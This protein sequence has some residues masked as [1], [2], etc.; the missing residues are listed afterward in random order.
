MQIAEQIIANRPYDS[1]NSFYKINSFQGS[2]VTPS[3][4]IQLIKAGCFDCFNTNR[5]AVMK[6]YFVLSNQKPD[7]LTMQ[8]MSSIKSVMKL[9]KE[10][11]GGYNFYKYI[12][13]KQFYFG[14]HPKFKSKKLYWLDN[15]ALRF[16]NKNCTEA[17]NGTDYWEEDDKIV[18][19][20]KSIEKIL[21]PKLDNVKDYINTSKFIDEYY[22][23]SLRAKYNEALPNQDPNHWSM[24][25]VSYY[26]GEHEMHNIDYDRYNLTHFADIPAE[27]EFVE[28]TSRGRT[29]KQFDLYA[30]CGTVVAKNDNNHYFSLL[31]PDNEVVNCKLHRGAYAA[32]K[33]QYSEV[34]DGKKTVLEKPWLSRGTMLIVSGYRRGEE[35]V[36]KKYSNSIYRHQLQKVLSINQNGNTIIQ[37]ERLGGEE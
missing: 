32:Y 5:I 17:I 10:V 22:K 36:C 2:L 12:T 20:D 34:V 18:V 3:K 8:N 11:F 13:Q 19:V 28:R 16:F 29:W 37:S 7:K 23:A 21:K 30:I 25:T 27:P 31:T 35:F 4:F 15:K 24:E 6:R 1:F 33:A 14:P 9:P 26:S